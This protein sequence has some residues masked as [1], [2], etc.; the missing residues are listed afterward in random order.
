MRVR[1]HG[2][3]IAPEHHKRVFERFYRVR[4]GTGSTRGSG[5]GLSLVKRIIE[6]HRGRAWVEN[7][8]GGGARVSFSIPFSSLAGG[9]ATTAFSSWRGEPS[10][11]PPED[12]LPGT[13]T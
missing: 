2:P 10:G 6:A 1:D 9:G 8:D 3:G 7:A 5:I 11:P 13:S 4:S 12:D